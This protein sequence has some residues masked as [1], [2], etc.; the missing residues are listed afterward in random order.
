M[1]LNG[2]DIE[3]SEI[4]YLGNNLNISCNDKL[5]C[6]IKTSHFIGYVNKLIVNFGHLRGNVLNKLFKLYCCSFYGSQMWR[7][8]SVY[9]NKVCTAWNIAVCKIYNLPYTTH[10]WFLGPLMNQPHIS[11]QLQERCIRFLHNMK[12]SQNEIV[13][14]CYRNAVRNVNTPIGH[15]IAFLRNTLGIDID[16]YEITPDISLP[17]VY[18]TN[19]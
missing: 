7:L 6:Q 5:D 4:K 15:N 1:T 3:W 12:T 2:N 8:G 10:Q 18:L 14:T 13:L 11:Y 17:K 19:E 16:N 9:F